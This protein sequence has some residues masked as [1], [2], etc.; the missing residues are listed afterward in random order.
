MPT[1]GPCGGC[2][3]EKRNSVIE[4]TVKWFNAEQGFGF[5]APDDGSRDAH[6]RHGN[7]PA[8]S[9]S[10]DGGGSVFDAHGRCAQIQPL[11]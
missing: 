3:T 9:F 2:A 7:A 10:N 11:G 5:I 4:G 1:A 6:T 8:P